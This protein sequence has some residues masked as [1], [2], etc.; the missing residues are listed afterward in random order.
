MCQSVIQWQNDGSFDLSIH[1]CQFPIPP[2]VMRLEHIGTGMSD[3]AAAKRKAEAKYQ[4]HDCANRFGCSLTEVER[5]PVAPMK[6]ELG[7]FE[8][9][10]KH[11][12]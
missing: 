3:R 10:F 12:S 9:A 2:G 8:K 6:E 5:Q 4:F 7:Y 1:Y 11:R